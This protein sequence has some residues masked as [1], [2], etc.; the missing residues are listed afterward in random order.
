M[1]CNGTS[2]HQQHAHYAV[3]KC[4]FQ[5]SR[6]VLSATLWSCDKDAGLYHPSHG[7]GC[8]M[9]WQ[10]NQ[11]IY[12]FCQLCTCSVTKFVIFFTATKFLVLWIDCPGQ[13]SFPVVIQSKHVT[14]AEVHSIVL[15]QGIEC[16]PQS[17]SSLRLAERRTP[18]AEISVQLTIG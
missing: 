17:A 12:H 6:R 16:Q 14:L 15:L 7:V 3:D 1:H 11:L 4:T 2:S 8:Q 5:N 13:V 18:K 9:L 10:R